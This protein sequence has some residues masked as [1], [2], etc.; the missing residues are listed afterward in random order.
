MGIDHAEVGSTL[1]QKWSLSEDLVNATS[2]HHVPE[3]NHHRLVWVVHEA[4][5]FV[6]KMGYLASKDFAGAWLD[7]K[8]FEILRLG[9]EEIE[10]TLQEIPDEIEKAT[11]FLST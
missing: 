5:C 4:N 2:Y 6:E 10:A 3:E 8:A 7:E 1:A 11:I 9:E